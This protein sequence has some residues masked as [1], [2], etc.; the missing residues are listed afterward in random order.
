M[1]KAHLTLLSCLFLL[2]CF[3]VVYIFSQSQIIEKL[4]TQYHSTVPDQRLEAAILL[5]KHYIIINMDSATFYLKKAEEFLSE[6]T[7]NE[8]KA[9]F[10][11][12]QG[13]ITLTMGYQKPALHYLDSAEKLYQKCVRTDNIQIKMGNLYNTRG[14]VYQQM[15]DW[16]KALFNYLEALK[17]YEKTNFTKGIY[18][19]YSNISWINYRKQF[20]PDAFMYAHKALYLQQSQQDSVGISKTLNNLGIY[21]AENKNYDSAVYY[22]ERS[23]QIRE[24]LNLKGELLYSYNN[25]GGVYTLMQ[26]HNLALKEYQKGLKISEEF[27]RPDNIAHCYGNIGK[28]YEDMGNYALAKEYYE[29][30]RQITEKYQLRDLLS[31]A[32]LGLANLYQ[33]AGNWKLAYEYL[34]QHVQLND[35]LLNKENIT[36]MTEMQ[37]KYE[38]EKKEQENKIL[39]QSNRIKDLEIQKKQAVIRWQIILFSLSTLIL[40][41]SG[42]VL[43]IHQRQKLK[44][45]SEQEKYKAM[46]L[47]EEQERMRIAQELHDGIGQVLSTTKLILSSTQE[48]LTDPNLLEY[49]M[50]LLD[51]A[52]QEVRNISHNL[53]PAAFMRG[54]LL[55]AIEELV[56]QINASHKITVRLN[57]V[58]IPQTNSKEEIILYRVI[59]EVL[60]NMVKHAQATQIDIDIRVEDDKLVF[61]IKDDGKG[62][63][64]T[65]IQNSKGMGWKSILSRVG[66]LNAKLSI[67]S[68]IGKGTT[69]QI[70]VQ[71]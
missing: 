32:Y 10:L 67:D 70:N 1:R 21:H 14:N 12:V 34:D 15:S 66:L 65:Q 22:F 50:Q 62:F 6:S 49:P 31:N 60:N 68:R 18:G 23:I 36:A 17:L 52:C 51:N 48:Q 27:D 63:D 54:G 38:T 44:Q 26:K 16:E 53:A 25:L 28:T 41:L 3:N 29:K 55:P 69:V 33:K 40:G 11:R 19:A 24:R 35:S 42:Y 61:C 30:Y 2:D 4:I 5:A 59:Q 71:I 56:A 47:A 58:D 45:R 13:D 43:Y 9:D 46:L 64:V 39:T 57:K 20:Y 8:L 37:T 7:P